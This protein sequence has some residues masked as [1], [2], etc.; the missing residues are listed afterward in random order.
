MNLD[1]R[2]GDC[3]EVMAG[4]EPGSVR[5]C[6]TSP[7][8]FGLR[9]YGTAKWEGGDEACD[10]KAPPSGGRGSSAM[11][12]GESHERWIAKLDDTLNYRGTCAKCGATR[13]DSQIGLER[14]PERI[15]AHLRG[16]RDEG[17][18]FGDA[19]LGVLR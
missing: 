10:H 2:E 18:A 17:K 8:Y 3:R 19:I 13:I 7:P 12:S 4:M 11:N 5:C 1:I 16:V 6:V 15:G 9:D 14:T